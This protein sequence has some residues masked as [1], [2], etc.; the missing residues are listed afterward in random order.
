MQNSKRKYTELK[1][2]TRF[3]PIYILY[4]P[5]KRNNPQKEGGEKGRNVNNSQGYNVFKII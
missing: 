5:R 2:L 1:P 3:M 4:K